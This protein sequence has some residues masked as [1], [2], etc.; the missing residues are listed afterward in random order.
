MNLS[1]TATMGT[2]ER[3]RCKEVLSKS[4]CMDFLSAGTKKVAFVERWLLSEVQLYQRI[5][6]MVVLPMMEH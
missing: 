6:N 2:E 3:D 4:Q 5:P 1:T